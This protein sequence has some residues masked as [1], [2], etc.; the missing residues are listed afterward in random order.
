[1]PLT[2]TSSC[3]IANTTAPRTPSPRTTCIS[4]SATP[5]TRSG[6]SDAAMMPSTISP[7]RT[8]AAAPRADGRQLRRLA[9]LSSKARRRVATW[10][11]GCADEGG[12]TRPRCPV[13]VCTCSRRS[14][15]DD[16]AGPRHPD[17]S[18]Y[19]HL[20]RRSTVPALRSKSEAASSASNEALR[21]ARRCQV[22]RSGRRE[23][24]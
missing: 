13:P 6:D 22:C 23:G 9:K 4:S 1:M 19:G 20:T 10:R 21:S 15:I 8:P 17:R 16:F 24:C 14:S 5:I 12:R 7:A 18:M 2:A 11:P 3:T